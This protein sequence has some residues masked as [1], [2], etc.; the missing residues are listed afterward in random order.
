VILLDTHVLLW[1]L[2]SPEKLSRKAHQATNKHS[3]LAISSIS[4]WEIALLCKHGKISLSP[5]MHAWI[6]KVQS[7]PLLDIIPIDHQIA[8]K[9]IDLPD[10]HQDPADRFIVATAMELNCPLI[11]KDTTIPQHPH[12]TTIW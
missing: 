5:N 2:D 9:S 6:K 7:I 10:I 12:L 11:T 4:L 3:S 8:L 1:W